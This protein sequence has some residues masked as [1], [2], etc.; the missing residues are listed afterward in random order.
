MQVGID[1][2][3]MHTNFGGHCL[4]SF[5]DKI[6][7]AMKKFIQLELAQKIHSSRAFRKIKYNF[8]HFFAII[9]WE[10]C[11]Q[12]Y[13]P[14]LLQSHLLTLRTAFSNEVLSS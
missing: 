3:C 11:Q 12:N 14:F 10:L 7:K 8:I 4:S 9:H 2:K 1:V 5:E 13:V 6:T